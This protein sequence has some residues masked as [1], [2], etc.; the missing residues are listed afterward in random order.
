MK[1]SRSQVVYTMFVFGN[2]SSDGSKKSKPRII[3]EMQKVSPRKVKPEKLFGAD[4]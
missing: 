1:N 2:K 4:P 3:Q